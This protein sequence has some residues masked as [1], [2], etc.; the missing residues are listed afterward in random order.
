MLPRTH[1]VGRTQIKEARLNDLGWDCC[2]AL[3]RIDAESSLRD[4]RSHVL[5]YQAGG[6]AERYRVKVARTHHHAA[7]R[8]QRLLKMQMRRTNEKIRLWLV[9]ESFVAMP[10]SNF[11]QMDSG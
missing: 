5:S 10:G 3:T 2:C 9:F 6:S 11:R 7:K 4:G 1:N 8:A